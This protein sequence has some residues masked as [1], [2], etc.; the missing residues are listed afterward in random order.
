M[1]HGDAREGRWR[2]N[3]RMEWVASTLHTTSELCV[4]SITTADAHTSAASSRLNWLPCR[5]KWSRQFRPKTKSGFCACAITFQTQSTMRICRSQ[6]PCGLR[7]FACWG[8][9]FKSR[10]AHGCLP[11]G[12][13]VCCQTKFSAS[14]RSPIHRSRTECGVSERDRKASKIS[15]LSPHGRVGGWGEHDAYLWGNKCDCMAVTLILSRKNG[16]LPD[17]WFFVSGYFFAAL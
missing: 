4:S 14:G 10:R 11:L 12:D 1:A 16:E 17:F 3:W 13:V 7:P 2:G 8:S 5:F 9:A 15:R 6:W